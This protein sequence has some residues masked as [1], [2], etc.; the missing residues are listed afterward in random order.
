MQTKEFRHLKN[1]FQISTNKYQL[2]W[3]TWGLPWAETELD[4]CELDAV[5]IPCR[6]LESRCLVKIKRAEIKR[7]GFIPNFFGI[8]G[9]PVSEVTLGTALGRCEGPELRESSSR[10]SLVLLRLRNCRDGWECCRQGCLQ[11]SL[12]PRFSGKCHFESRNGSWQRSSLPCRAHF[13]SLTR[14]LQGWTFLP[15]VGAGSALI[16]C[17]WQALDNSN[18]HSI[19]QCTVSLLEPN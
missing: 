18:F 7:R 2:Y 9:I 5:K 6:L 19:T 17:W 14:C 1:N 13:A 11:P 12:S 3:N 8:N 4:N 16:M 15:G 10:Q